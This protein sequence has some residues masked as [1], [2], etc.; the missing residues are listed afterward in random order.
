[1]RVNVVIF[2]Q[3]NIPRFAKLTGLDEPSIEKL[4]ALAEE[5]NKYCIFTVE[6]SE[7]AWRRIKNERF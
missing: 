5:Q 1:M 3:S 7:D 6:M 2:H 4:Y